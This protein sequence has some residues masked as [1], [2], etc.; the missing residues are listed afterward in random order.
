MKF[1]DPSGE[2]RE[3]RN[4][5]PHWEQDA[6]T[7]FITFRLGDSIPLEVV[8]ELNNERKTWLQFNPQPWS[9]KTEREFHQRF[10]A[11]IDEWMDRGHGECLLR[12]ADLRA[13][14]LDALLRGHKQS[15]LMRIFVIMPNHV[16]LLVSLD[17]VPLSAAVKRWKGSSAAAING[18]LG[19]SGC[20][21]QKDYFDRLIRGPVHFGNVVRYIQRNPSKAQL[22]EGEFTLWEG[23]AE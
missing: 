18:L 15:Y 1:Y 5:L 12:R 7:Y 4:N 11:K 21:W 3:Y 19:R 9:E 17:D 23:S 13:G 20:L 10:S 16:H 2:T 8:R 22:H 6:A 14:V